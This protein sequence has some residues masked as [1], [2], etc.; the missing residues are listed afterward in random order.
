MRNTNIFKMLAMAVV[1]GMA[2]GAPMPAFAASG[3]DGERVRLVGTVTAIDLQG[4]NFTVTDRN[5]A[6]TKIFVNPTTEFEIEKGKDFFGDDDIPFKDLR[7][8]DWVKVKSYLVS[9]ELEAAD[10]EI[11]RTK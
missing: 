6:V 5:K 3:N 1:L 11:Y 4:E 8:G 7:V 9:G 2:L 10:V